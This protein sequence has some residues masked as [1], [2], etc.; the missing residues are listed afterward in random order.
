MLLGVRGSKRTILVPDLPDSH[1]IF[2]LLLTGFALYLFTRDRLP[3]EASGLTILVI[4]ILSF[5]LIPYEADGEVLAP[6][7]FLTG[8]GHEALIAICALMIM[9]K[10]LETTGALQPLAVFLA[11]AWMARPRL[12]SFAT[13]LI[14]AILSASQ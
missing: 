2:V 12:A 5:Q 11:K 6:T 10:G 13:L 3:L 8:F 1:G 14:S 7:T 9:G 4:L